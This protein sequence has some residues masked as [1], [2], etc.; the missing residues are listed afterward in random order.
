MKISKLLTLITM[1]L[2]AVSSCD[3]TEEII[4]N[5]TTISGIEASEDVE[6]AFIP[7]NTVGYGITTDMDL[8]AVLK[9][10]TGVDGTL[11]A[12]K[13]IK[14]TGLNMEAIAPEDSNFDFLDEVTLYVKTDT[15][16]KKMIAYASDIEKGQ[17]KIILTTTND[18]LDAYAKSENL[19]L[20]VEYKSNSTEINR[21]VRFNMTFEAKVNL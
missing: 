20:I 16:E 6:L 5:I 2:F 21:T 1:I 13:E 19:E 12:V 17:D 10:E 9:E 8:R 15:E 14:L 11:D 3:E 18:T 7:L 4:D